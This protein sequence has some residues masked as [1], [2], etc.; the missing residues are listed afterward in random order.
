MSAFKMISPDQ[1][2]H[3]LA[4]GGTIIDVRTQAEHT[5]KCLEKAH[6][7]IPMDQINAE[8]LR[9]KHGLGFNSTLY[10]L[11]LGGKRAAVV[12]QQL[13]SEGFTDVH[14]IDGGIMGCEK[15]GASIVKG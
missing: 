12:A 2:D 7:H 8:V 6:L 13:A 14:V 4:T 11:C 9:A 10:I 1:I 3:M 15:C 5:D